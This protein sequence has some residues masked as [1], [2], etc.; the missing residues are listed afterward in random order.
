MATFWA[1]IMGFPWPATDAAADVVAARQ[2]PKPAAS[3][4]GG[5]LPGPL[6]RGDVGRYRRIFE[7]QAAG[8]LAAADRLIA[9][10][11]NPL[12]LGHVLWQRYL[13]PTAHRSTYAELE[14]WLEQYADHPGADRIHQL[15]VRRQ[16]A[17]AKPP[18]APVP[19][20]L[21]G[22]G[23]DGPELTRVSYQGERERSSAEEETIRAWRLEI[24][25]LV[26]DGLPQLAEV[27]AERPEILALVD[28]VEAD[29]ARWTVARGYLSA[30]EHAKALALAG[31]AAA[32]SGSVVPE[33][34]WTAGIS[35]WHLGRTRLAGWHFATLAKAAATAPG[36][37]SRAAFW[38]ARAYLLEFKPQ[39]VKH[40]LRLA[41][42]EH[43]FYGLLAQTVLGDPLAREPDPVSREQRVPE[44]LLR[45]PGAQRA[46]ALGQ[47]GEDERAESEIR[48]LAGRVSAEHIV[49]LIALAERLDL[50]AAQMRLAQSLEASENGYHFGALYPVP[51]WQPADGYSLDRA[52]IYSIMRAESA[53][54]P[55]AESHAG[56]RGLMQV[57][58]ATAR[59]LASRGALT[60]P[61]HADLLDPETSIRYGQAYLAHLLQRSPIG[62]NLIYVAA[63]YNAG[64]TRVA[65]GREQ[66]A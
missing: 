59:Y 34:R 7:L 47:V 55:S 53:F 30:G 28:P 6:D 4:A 17:G 60:P 46:L 49:D 13:H 23:Q 43:D 26:G 44:L 29:L 36:E 8:D 62:D 18:A 41:A 20:Y 64:P 56:A 32:R 22:S 57:M 58:P 11:G 50:P 66:L 10:L 65:R 31:R 54:D 42:A 14:A 15:A 52:L 9:G 37:R 45:F 1:C 2:G 33:I 61:R 38:A 3:A 27:E 24:E 63:A 40:F 5:V 48:K 35:A 51:S 25:R 16:P 21:G 39:Q 19:G 12:L